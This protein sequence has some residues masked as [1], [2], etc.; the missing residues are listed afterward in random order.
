MRDAVLVV[1]DDVIFGRQIKRTLGT[2]AVVTVAGFGEHAVREV[3]KEHGRY[4]LALID[5]RLP[6]IDGC[7]VAR[8]I[9]AIDDGIRLV[10]LTGAPAP[11]EAS[12]GAIV[13]ADARFVLKP[14]GADELRSMLE[15]ARAVMPVAR[16]DAIVSQF[17]KDTEL[18]DP[19]T[20]AEEYLLRLAAHGHR[21]RELAA[22]LGITEDAVK[23]RVRAIVAKWN[24]AYAGQGDGTRVSNL[25][26]V[27][28]EVL[29]RALEVSSGVRRRP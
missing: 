29:G 27:V 26:E 13:V 21:R 20:D 23:M 22:P 28:R 25:E 12:Q 16:I 18:T 2:R 5:Y 15:E 14:I 6:D 9:R 4:L 19:L 1:D 3:E 7:E 17:A 24:G 11:H 10:V 8:R